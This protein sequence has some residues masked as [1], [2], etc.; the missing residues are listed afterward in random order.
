MAQNGK[1]QNTIQD[2]RMTKLEEDFREVCSN[3]NHEIG[4]VRDSIAIVKQDVAQVKTNVDWLM[5]S[6]WVVATASIGA[7]ITTIVTFMAKR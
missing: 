7:L 4:E 3:Y 6:Y 1:Y 2:Q 5:R